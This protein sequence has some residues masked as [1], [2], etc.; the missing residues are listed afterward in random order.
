M[1]TMVAQAAPSKNLWPRWQVTDPVSTKTINH[2][3]WGQ[4]LSKYVR[5]NAQG[6]NLVAYN[7]VTARDKQNLQQYITYLQSIPIDNYSRPVQEAYWINLYNAETVNLVLQH[8]PVKSI[9]DINIS[10]GLFKKGPWDAKV[11]TVEG[12]KLS[13]N[14]IEHRILRP[15]WNDPRLHYS[16]NC[17]SISCPNLQK[18]PF[19]G[20]NINRQLNRAATQYINSPRGVDIKQGKLI[21]SSI[22]DWYRPDFGGTTQDVIKHLKEYAKPALR[23]QLNG[24]NKISGYEYN[25]NLNQ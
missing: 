23:Q 2:N 15:I 14:D 8:Y 25:W 6:L 22:Y 3:A 4:F 12:Q 1:I 10:P 11:L 20:A 19:T 5:T 16:V 13:L 17:A 18:Q 21:L 9:L 7:K 24:Y